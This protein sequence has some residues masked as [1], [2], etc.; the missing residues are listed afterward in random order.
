[1]KDG[2]GKE[3]RPR[4]G[5]HGGKDNRQSDRASF[6]EQQANNA[7]SSGGQIAARRLLPQPNSMAAGQAHATPTGFMA[8]DAGP[9]AFA[10]TRIPAED[11]ARGMNS[12]PS[13]RETAL[14]VTYTEYAHRDESGG[15]PYV[16]PRMFNVPQQQLG[17]MAPPAP[18][19]VHAQGGFFFGGMQGHIV[20]PHLIGRSGR[21]AR[22]ELPW[23]QPPI[24]LFPPMKLDASNNAGNV[25]RSRKVHAQGLDPWFGSPT[26]NAERR[27]R[28]RTL[29]SG[30]PRSPATAQGPVSS[31]RTNNDKAPASSSEAEG[32]GLISRSSGDDEDLKN[33][34]LSERRRMGKLD[35]NTLLEA[36]RKRNRESAHRSRKVRRGVHQPQHVPQSQHTQLSY[37]FPCLVCY[38]RCPCDP[39][40]S[41]PDK[42]V[43]ETI[44][45]PSHWN[46]AL[47]SHVNLSTSAWR[48]VT[49]ALY[50]R[51]TQRAATLSTLEKELS[52]LRK[53]HEKL[54]EVV[55]ELRSKL[56]TNGM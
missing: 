49:D 33:M 36:R 30:D 48:I 6:G 4:R 23:H 2:D 31:P 26:S 42:D 55:N 45:T 29:D 18:H 8:A 28:R 9:G 10:E 7:T 37:L 34:S 38:P 17:A 39:P 20:Q 12:R 27:T 44:S 15:Y 35:R 40:R 19:L 43:P 22:D 46:E 51:E 25:Q 21:Y 3:A 47:T 53:D 52:D 24:T 41:I 56:N 11:G 14:G 13:A 32:T 54:K 5:G 16:D 50:T 1:M